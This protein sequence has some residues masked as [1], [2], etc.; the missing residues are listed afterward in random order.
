MVGRVLKN[1]E[2]RRW[3]ITIVLQLIRSE[4]NVRTMKDIFV[5]SLSRRRYLV[6]DIIEAVSSHTYR[7]INM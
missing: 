5:F 6:N 3:K 4:N 2:I 1:D 7:F